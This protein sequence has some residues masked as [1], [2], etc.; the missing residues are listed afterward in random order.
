[1]NVSPVQGEKGIFGKEIILDRTLAMVERM[2]KPA[3]KLA[4]SFG[5]D[6][7]V[8][9]KDEESRLKASPPSSG[10]RG[11]SF[12]I[13]VYCPQAQ[14]SDSAMKAKVQG[15]VVLKVV[16]GADGRAQKISVQQALPCGLD[17]QSINAV[18]DWKFRPATG[19]TAIERPS[20]KLSRLRC[21]YTRAS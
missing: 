5:E 6:K 17:Q 19:P 2:V 18:K 14:Y 11:Y 15:T 1:V 8:W 7:T 10:T 21:T 12:P 3:P 20:G 9:A 4:A 16:I 13:C